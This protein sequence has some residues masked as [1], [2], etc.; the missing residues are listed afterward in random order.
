MQIDAFIFQGP[1]EALDVDVV[2]IPGFAI[3]RYLGLCPLQPVG[4]VEGRELRPLVR[5]HDLGRAEL[6]DGLVQRLEAEVCL[7]RV[8]YPPS[9]HLA[10]EPVHDGHQVEKAFP[11]RQVGDVRAPDLV[12]P[13]HPQP[14]QQIGV[15]LVPL[16]RLAGIG[17][18]VGKHFEMRWT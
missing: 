14:T 18:L 8:R 15:G 12:G 3:H 13:V 16:R 11:H 9:Q 1:P 2:Q 6:V 5:I 4:P 10:G 17:L 7:Q